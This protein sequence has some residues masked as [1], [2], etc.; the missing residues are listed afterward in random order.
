MKL[1]KSNFIVNIFRKL[2]FNFLK[3]YHARG[4]VNEIALG[5]AIGT[6]WGVF[7]TFGLSTIL[8]L[9]LYKLF[10][11]N[12]PVAISAAFIS[13][14]ITSPF[15][16]MISFK[17]GIF[18]I[19]TDLIF[20]YENWNQNISKFGFVMFIGSTIVSTITAIFVYFIVKYTFTYRHQKKIEKL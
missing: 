7:P 18:F 4:S 9:M 20:E 6:F 1:I 12:L 15:L 3:I 16:L 14:P 2:K 8:T 17:V 5:A 10:R 19:N 11:F 13:N